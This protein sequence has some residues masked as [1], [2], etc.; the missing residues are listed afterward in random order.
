[1]QIFISSYFFAVSFTSKYFISRFYRRVKNLDYNNA[2]R[3][4]LIWML[5]TTRSG[6]KTH[7]KRMNERLTER[8]N[9][10]CSTMNTKKTHQW[11]TWKTTL[12]ETFFL[13]F[14]NTRKKLTHLTTTKT[15]EEWSFFS[16]SFCLSVHFNFGAFAEKPWIMAIGQQKVLNTIIL[17]RNFSSDFHRK[18]RSCGTGFVHRWLFDH[19]AVY[20][21]RIPKYALFH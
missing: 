12:C 19:L 21:R 13:T 11:N 15:T 18:D 1:M 9:Q 4:S 3:K 2:K 8:I 7:R 17:I 10:K 20:L 14:N 16:F 6:E 5:T